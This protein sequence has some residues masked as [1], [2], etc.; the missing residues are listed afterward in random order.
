MTIS[1]TLAIL[2]LPGGSEWIVI[3]LIGLLVFGR[4]LP[5]VGRSL[6][7]SIV[8]FKKGIKGVEDEIEAESAEPLKPYDRR[9]GG[10]EEELRRLQQ[11]GEAAEELKRV[12][13]QQQQQ[14]HQGNG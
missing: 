10:D 8:E 3:A 7:R 5:E 13:Q 6:G 14:Q 12:S 2:G 4:R 11:Q 9:L 1:S